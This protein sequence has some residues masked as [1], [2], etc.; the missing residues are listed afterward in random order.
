MH[1]I[2][3][4]HDRRGG[5]VK[6][7]LGERKPRIIVSIAKKKQ[8][9]ATTIRNHRIGLATNWEVLWRLSQPT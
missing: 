8:L 4:Q 6:V 7:Q 5:V 2:Q 1:D 3:L 9:I